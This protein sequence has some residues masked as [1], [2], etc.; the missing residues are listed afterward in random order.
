M[1]GTSTRLREGTLNPPL[2]VF[3]DPWIGAS[4][5]KSYLF[6]DGGNHQISFSGPPTFAYT[7]G[8]NGL[9]AAQT[10]NWIQAQEWIGYRINFELFDPDNPL[11]SQFLNPK[12]NL[13]TALVVLGEGADGMAAPE[14]EQTRSARVMGAQRMTEVM[15]QVG[16]SGRARR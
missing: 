11:W 7:V 16:R 14:N 15:I 12:N 10:L 3:N 8:S 13:Q 9:S 1:N 2:T 6:R 4:N 5:P